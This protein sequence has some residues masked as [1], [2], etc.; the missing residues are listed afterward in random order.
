[1]LPE[2]VRIRVNLVA[3]LGSP[4]REPPILIGLRLKAMNRGLWKH[5]SKNAPGVSIEGTHIDNRSNGPSFHTQ[6]RQPG[7]LQDPV[8]MEKSL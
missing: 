6:Q 2:S 7:R 3:G 1:M 4:V 8:V 5:A